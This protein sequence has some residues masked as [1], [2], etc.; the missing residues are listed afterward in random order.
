MGEGAMCVT[1]YV[2][3]YVKRLYRL[4]CVCAY[5]STHT[6]VYLA[7]TLYMDMLVCAY[8]ICVCERAYVCLCTV[9]HVVQAVQCG[10]CW[11]SS[12]Q[13]DQKCVVSIECIHVKGSRRAGKEKRDACVHVN[14]SV[15]QV[16]IE[17]L[18]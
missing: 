17:L 2:S 12:I 8:T 4:W 13:A 1:V 11:S 15:Q 3:R 14:W 16:T 9:R 10:R 18:N 6:Q 5:A 7:M